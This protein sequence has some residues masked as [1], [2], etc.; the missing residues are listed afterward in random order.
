MEKTPAKKNT[1]RFGLQL[2]L[3]GVVLVLLPAGSWL[4]LQ[5]GLDY[6][7]ELMGEL[8]ELGPIQPYNPTV[9]VGEDFDWDGLQGKVVVASFIQLTD[10]DEV[11][12]IGLV[13]QQLHDQFDERGDVF[14]LVHV[15]ADTE[16][17]VRAFVKTYDLE[18]AEQCYFF[19]VSAGKLESIAD[20]NYHL[21]SS[22]LP[23][24]K[25]LIA[26]ADPKLTVRK[27]YDIALPEERKRLI[28]HIALLMP[29]QTEKD[30]IFKRETE[31]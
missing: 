4:Y 22:E 2:L 20:E 26:V 16:E 5:R 19:R 11:E 14:F 6:R 8:R 24:K 25:G 21:K 31:K 12:Q 29:R 18:D 27:F 17:Q 10:S 30:L 13:L 7:K 23:F 9:L 28:E 15:Q 3:L 1:K